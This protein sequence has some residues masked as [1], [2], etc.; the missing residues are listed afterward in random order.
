MFSKVTMKSQ[1]I[2]RFTGIL[3]FMGVIVVKSFVPNRLLVTTTS[4]LAEKNSKLT[5]WVVENLENEGESITSFDEVRAGENDILPLDGLRVGKV[6]VFAA[7]S[8][9]ADK[10]EHD[11]EF[12][13]KLL[14]GRNGW[15]T[16]VHPTTRLCI[17][18]LCHPDVIAGGEALLD[19]GCG[20]GI[21]S[22]AALGMGASR[23]IGVDV[24][25]EAL[26][27]SER[28][29]ELNHLDDRFE[30]F[31]TREII[32]YCLPPVDICVA[33]ILIGQLV[34]PSMIAAIVT[35]MAPG[36][37]L[38]LSGIRPSQVKS[39]KT[40][41]DEYVDWIDDQYAELA[42]CDTEMCHNSY[43]FDVGDWARVVGKV[44]QE[45]MDIEKMSE[46]AVL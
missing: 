32:P 14:A 17:E 45:G 43:G 29:L 40:A 5:D 1:S 16:G 11:D 44:K 3:L 7:G 13:I 18:W 15:G 9:I 21:L 41:Y 23:A 2:I 34:R 39:L 31:H 27:A 12:Q 46:L 33:N 24:E 4:I 8:P 35:N 25:A 10:S 30:G 6:R 20:S 26:V 37:L 38:C 42:A 19:Y 36:S 28:N 22:I